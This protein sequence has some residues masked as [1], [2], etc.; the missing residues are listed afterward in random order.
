MNKQFS[1]YETVASGFTNNMYLP[2]VPLDQWSLDEC[3][4]ALCAKAKGDVL[5]C[6]GCENK[7]RYGKRIV[8]LLKPVEIEG[9]QNVSVNARARKAKADKEKRYLEAIASGNTTR[10]AKEHGY[11]SAYDFTYQ[12]KKTF[13]GMT[14]EQARKRLADMG[15]S[16]PAKVDPVAVEVAACDLQMLELPEAVKPAPVVSNRLKIAA[17]DGEYFNYRRTEDGICLARK[18]G[19]IV[20]VLTDVNAICAEIRAAFEIME[21]RSETE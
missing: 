15:D 13:P 10:W 7:C 12:A 2:K 4:R 1:G 3:R 17:V 19:G 8:E 6:E 9:E 16:I 18:E 20:M 21:G 11:K 14:I 5:F